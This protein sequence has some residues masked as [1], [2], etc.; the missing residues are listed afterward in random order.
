MPRSIVRHLYVVFTHLGGFGLL[1]MGIADSSILVFV[2]LGNDLLFIA[3]TVRNNKLMVYY[4]VMA[5]IGSVIGCLTADFV[6]RKGG[7]KGME[8]IVPGKYLPRIKK[9]IEKKA[10][11]GLAFASL[12][13]PPFPFKAFVAAAAALL[14]SRRRLLIVISAS[15]LARFLIEGGI[16]ILVGRRLLRWARSPVLEY[17]VVALIVISVVGTILPIVRSFKRSKNATA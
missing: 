2:P 17:F 15:R 10:A 14:Y 12:M 11:W 3:M 1:V 9:V 16:T 7:E 6:S 8:R 5:M 13:P 4:A